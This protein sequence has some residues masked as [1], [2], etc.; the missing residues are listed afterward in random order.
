MPVELQVKLLR[1][2]QHGEIEKVGAAETTIVD[3]RII[4]AT[5]RNLQAMIED[6]AFREDLYYRLAVIPLDLP[7]LR[8]RPEDI[9][10][11]A[12]RFFLKAKEKHGRPDLTLPASLLAHFGGYRWPGN[13][14]ELENVIERLVVL[15]RGNEITLNNLPEFLRRERGVLE[16]L[17]LDLPPQ[18][19]SLDAI[20]KEL[21]LRAL[22]K[23][24]WNQTQAARYLDLSRKTLIYRMEKYDI[25][26]EQEPGDPAALQS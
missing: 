15:T 23:F 20:E 9:P 8:E 21:I 5:H 3:V 7:P 2:L 4:A 6:G 13:I 26:R 16:E 24:D 10:E 19:I 14:R 17:R 11:L 1:L 22:K 18:G 12:E 25:R